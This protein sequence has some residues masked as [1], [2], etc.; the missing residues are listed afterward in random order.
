MKY[1]VAFV[2]IGA[3][4]VGTAVVDTEEQERDLVE[5]T[6]RGLRIFGRFI[7]WI[8]PWIYYEP[9]KLLNGENR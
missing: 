7:G 1:R 4:S 6:P 8:T 5:G 9:P 2:G 3:D